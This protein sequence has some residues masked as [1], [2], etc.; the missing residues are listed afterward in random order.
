M[1]NINYSYEETFFSVETFSREQCGM[2]TPD[3][4]SRQEI[5]RQIPVQ[6]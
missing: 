5:S 3:K 4:K 2:I 6:S 1:R